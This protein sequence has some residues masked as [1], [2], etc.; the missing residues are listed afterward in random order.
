MRGISVVSSSSH[1]KTFW[2]APPLHWEWKSARG[3]C[4]SETFIFRHGITWWK[5]ST[6]L[7]KPLR[8]GT[9]LCPL[10]GRRWTHRYSGGLLPN[11]TR[12]GHRNRRFGTNRCPSEKRSHSTPTVTGKLG[13]AGNGAVLAVGSIIYS[14]PKKNTLGSGKGSALEGFRRG[15]KKK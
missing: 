7:I 8:M 1:M 9:R 2:H 10:L 11:S 6:Q 13:S 14:H 4:L 3:G 12:I 15:I 5:S